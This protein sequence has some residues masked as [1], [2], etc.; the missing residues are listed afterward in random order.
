MRG[1]GR[2]VMTAALCAWGAFGACGADVAE[3][4]A[5]KKD[6]PLDIRPS[7][8]FLG[9][10]NKYPEPELVRGLMAQGFEVGYSSWKAVDID[11][12]R[13][14]NVVLIQSLGAWE[15]EWTPAKA[16]E[17][18][19]YMRLGGGVITTVANGERFATE[20]KGWF[21]SLGLK[22]VHASVF[23]QSTWKKSLRSKYTY[24]GNFSL[25]KDVKP[26]PVTVA[27]QSLWYPQSVGGYGLP[28]AMPL[29][30]DAN[31]TVLVE[32]GPEA[33]ARHW[34]SKLCDPANKI[35]EIEGKKQAWPLIAARRVGN[36]RLVVVGIAPQYIFYAPHFP[37]FDGVC[38]DKG[39]DG[40]PSHFGILLVNALR[41]CAEPTFGKG[42]LGWLAGLFPPVEQGDSPP[43]DWSVKKFN[44]PGPWLRGVA[45][46]RSALSGGKGTVAEWAAA[47]AAEG[48]SFLVF[49]DDMSKLDEGAWK[50]LQRQCA[51]ASSATFRC[52]PGMRYQ[53]TIQTGGVNQQFV[54]DGVRTRGF[55]PK[56]FLD[57][58]N[59]I[60]IKEG[61]SE[62]PYFMDILQENPGGQGTTVGFMRHGSN[63]TPFWDYKLYGIF[64]CLTWESGKLVDDSFDKFLEAVAVNVNPTPYA[65]ALLDDPAQ[66]KGMLSS[67]APHLVVNGAP[68][69]RYPS[70]AGG[71]PQADL[72]VG[73]AGDPQNFG[74]GAYRAWYGPTVSEGPAAS[75]RFRGGYAWKRVEYPRYWID[76]YAANAKAD[77]FMPSYYRLPVRLD[78]ASTE[79]LAEIT[80]HDGPELFRR[81][82]PKGAKEFSAEF[83]IP[84]DRNRHLVAVVKDAKGR[85]AITP[86]IWTEQQQSLYNYCGDRINAPLGRGSEPGHG[87][88]WQEGV[89][90]M[91]PSKKVV[92]QLYPRSLPGTGC[93]SRR[94]QLEIAA[95]DLFIEKV[96]SSAYFKKLLPYMSNPWHN[97]TVPTPRGDVAHGWSRYEWYQKHNF[98]YVHHAVSGVHW[99]GY[100][101]GPTG[102][103]SNNAYHARQ[104]VWGETKRELAP[105]KDLGLLPGLSILAWEGDLP[106][107]GLALR[108]HR[109]DGTVAESR[110]GG[111]PKNVRQSGMLG[112][113][114][115]VSV[116][117]AFTLRV[118]G[119]E[120]GFAALA[121]LGK[122]EGQLR[123]GPASA[124]PVAAGKRYDWWFELVNDRVTNPVKPDSSWVSVATG[125]LADCW[126]GPT[127]AAADGAV[128]LRLRRNPLNVNSTPIIVDGV[129]SGWTCVLLETGSG[130]VRP[131]G[132]SGGRAFAQVDALEDGLEV[133]IGN[134]IR[135]DKPELCVSASQNT[136]PEG[137]ADGSWT[138]D[139]HNPTDAPLKTTLRVAAPFQAM[140]KEREKAVELPA[141]SSA[142]LIMR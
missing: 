90:K 128:K 6:P 110:L 39:T 83:W 112:D 77:W 16:A 122:N 2:L 91:E 44:A 47:A 14:Y 105:H 98:S 28:A 72:H 23:D 15:D 58:A 18:E 87:N 9:S 46:V 116:G 141:R 86:E 129:E 55:P 54:V 22:L 63:A 40:V 3:V 124:T 88:A 74:A 38:W 69:P 12:L 85:R 107:E 95:P 30:V 66:L 4:E 60:A 31:W 93:E 80:I 37:L 36:G 49:L 82:D 61:S 33:V 48:F 50:E 29:I 120:L 125:T 17:L 19:D 27:V 5:L 7:V 56:R 81:F 51:A 140:F 135:C 62:A 108:I 59:N 106:K 11:L 96:S 117:D 94:M 35:P 97:W 52:Y 111:D 114:D 99:D 75:L 130:L 113:G 70:L 138:I 53:M 131:V 109:S 115:A 42:N 34:E 137:K 139:V 136:T 78:V 134:L 119:K 68:D 73:G 26:H 84:Q 126:T 89:L 101:Y 43:V 65:V 100:P 10:P 133:A 67:G 25:T 64:S 13:R 142:Q 45:G 118:H 103:P 21:D 71:L 1:I 127:V 79:P 92:N 132:S 123:L 102:K 41:W 20:A 76:R 57:D 32:S 8:L 121:E 104:V 24:D